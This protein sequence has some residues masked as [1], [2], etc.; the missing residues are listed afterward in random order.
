[1]RKLPDFVFIIFEY[2]VTTNSAILFA[3]RVLDT[4]CYGRCLGTTETAL[5]WVQEYTVINFDSKDFSAHHLQPDS[6]IPNTGKDLKMS[7]S[8]L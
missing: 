8:F 2:V 3:T 7:L 4:L 5:E 6:Q 1:M